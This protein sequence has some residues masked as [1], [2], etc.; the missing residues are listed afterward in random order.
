MLGFLY[1][2]ALLAYIYSFVLFIRFFVWRRLA[3]SRFWRTKV[4]I[5]LSQIKSMA[6]SWGVNLPFFTIMV[7]ARNESK[8]I[9]RTV[10]NLMRLDYPKE[11]LQIIVVTDEKERISHAEKK[12][13]QVEGLYKILIGETTETKSVDLEEFLL[14]WVTESLPV[15]RLVYLAQRLD[16]RI[17]TANFAQDMKGLVFNFCSSILRDKPTDISNI[18]Y[19]VRKA[20]PGKTDRELM[21]IVSEILLQAR[22]SIRQIA[23]RIKLKR[24]IT[25]R[26]ASMV[27]R[28]YASTSATVMERISELDENIKNRGV[29]SVEAL[30]DLY[31]RFFKTTQ[32]VVCECIDSFKTSGF[33]LAHVEVPYDF[34]G[35]FGG[36]C[37]GVEVR[38]TK[39]RALNYAF[40][41]VDPQTCM[42]AFYDAESHPDPDVFLHAARHMLSDNPP[43]ILQGPLFQVRNYYRM[44]A[45]SKIGGLYKAIAHDWYLPL[46]FNRLPFVGG[47]NLHI[48][49]DLIQRMRGFDELSLT[50]DL[51]FGCRA[52]LYFGTKLTFLTVKS[53]EQTPPTMPQ[54]FRQRLRWASGHLQVISRIRNYPRPRLSVGDA[55]DYKRRARKLWWYLI[56]M[57][58]LEWM[59]YQLSTGIVLLMDLILLS[60]FFGATIPGPFFAENAILYW[61]LV[62]LNVPYLIFTLYC[63]LRYDEV[64]DRTFR[65]LTVAAGI[66]DFV[67]LFIASFVVFLLP[68]PYTWAVVLKAIGRA[69][70]TWVKTP[71]TGE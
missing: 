66:F 60:N 5:T 24:N 54:Y 19:D 21:E 1:T 11:F 10:E 40:S 15:G 27:P 50:E 70:K 41:E 31:D 9:R 18:Y 3:W 61:A 68:A 30:G 36:V 56:V 55:G 2:L 22:V 42:I 33:K 12:P 65:P 63:Y 17:A 46:M 51:E 34:D 35:E 64:F 4:D 69:P 44:G 48:S 29:T 25:K 39:G 13:E 71:R 58:P 67:K 7:P 26:V 43:D 62:G 47:T 23:V 32:Q 49:W 37:T 20:I 28:G 59:V 16:R 8:V 6:R 38:S 14:A 52:Y 53:T 57:G 45:L